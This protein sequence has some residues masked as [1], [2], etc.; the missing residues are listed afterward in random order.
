MINN[1]AGR[2][3]LEG[4]QSHS[5]RRSD[6]VVHGWY[7]DGGEEAQMRWDGTTWTSS[8]AQSKQRGGR[9]A[10]ASSQADAR[11]QAPFSLDRSAEWGA[12]P[13]RGPA[14]HQDSRSEPKGG[15][16]TADHSYVVHHEAHQRADEIKG[17]RRAG[18]LVVRG[19][20]R[21][22]QQRSTGGQVSTEVLSFRL[23]RYDSK[24]ERLRPVPVVLRGNMIVGGSR[25]A[26]QLNDGDEVE[27]RGVLQDG[28]LR[29]EAVVNLTTGAELR[30]RSG[31]QDL[32]DALSGKAGKKLRK[33]LIVTLSLIAS[34]IAVV[35][36]AFVLFVYFAQDS[37][38]QHVDRTTSQFERDKKDALRNFCMNVRDNGMK[39]PHECD[40]VL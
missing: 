8:T 6:A 30:S 19:T 28:T 29:A 18:I 36:T 13:S 26:G 17:D 40:G 5:T 33:G 25:I 22:V 20:A 23:E 3:G 12:A 1:S 39:L 7:A 2:T 15:K 11:N 35:I 21:A 34:V 4:A 16:T 31:L 37:F 24:G 38:Q 14:C 9:R 10:D 32:S 27:V